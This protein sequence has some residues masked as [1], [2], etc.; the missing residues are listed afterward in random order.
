MT[1]AETHLVFLWARL[2]SSGCKVQRGETGKAKGWDDINFI[3]LIFINMSYC[4]DSVVLQTPLFKICKKSD[5]DAKNDFHTTT[6]HKI[7]FTAWLIVSTSKIP[8][9]QYLENYNKKKKKSWYRSLRFFTFK[10]LDILQLKSCQFSLVD[11]I[12]DGVTVSKLLAFLTGRQTQIPILIIGLALINLISLTLGDIKK[13]KWKTN[14]H[15]E[16]N[17]ILLLKFKLSKL[18]RA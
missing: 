9:Y 13:I 16:N 12:C 17:K 2:A 11:R 6:K 1:R 3:L 10:E 14:T 4:T 8:W 15:P 5:Q 18:S 7:N